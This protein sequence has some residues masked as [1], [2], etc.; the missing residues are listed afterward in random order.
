MAL[1][2]YKRDMEGCS[3]CSSCKWVLFNQIKSRRFG[4]NCPSFTDITSTLTPARA[5]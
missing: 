2:D 1:E 4:K 5:R 3:R